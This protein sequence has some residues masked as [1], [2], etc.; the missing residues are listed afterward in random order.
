MET[1]FCFTDTENCGFGGKMNEPRKPSLGSAVR[2]KLSDITNS[3]QNPKSPNQ[4]EKP[5][6]I[7]FTPK[8]YIEQLQKDNVALKQLL[9]ER[10]KILELTGVEITKM[11]INMQKLQQ[12]NRLLAQANSQLTME[13]SLDK[14]RLKAMQHE[15]CCRGNLIIVKDMELQE[16]AATKPCQKSCTAKKSEMEK[17][18]AVE[19]GGGDNKPC[20]LNRRRQ[21]KIQSMGSSGVEEL[22]D[23]KEGVNRRRQSRIR[24]L[25]SSAVEEQGEIVEKADDK[26]EEVKEKPLPAHGDDIK[27]SSLSRSR[28]SRI[29]ALGSLAVKEQV[30]AKEKSKDKRKSAAWINSEHR[31]ATDEKSDSKR[32][33]LRRQ[34]AKFKPEQVEPTQDSFEIEDAKFLPSALLDE[35]MPNGSASSTTDEVNE[36]KIELNHDTPARR[37][38]SIGRPAR[39]A[40]EKVQSYKEIPLNIKMRRSN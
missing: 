21:S 37:R 31:E 8:E 25:E 36:R 32:A 22:L 13:H 12:Q 30:T 29:Q 16:R 39:R 18:G 27:P 2:K 4:Q 10:N 11:R 15:L 33:C 38:S 23:A 35:E 1:G 40:A 14:D 19:D 17:V 5:T 20:N 3:Q 9:Q 28:R 26:S 7:S 24:P 34:S 6:R